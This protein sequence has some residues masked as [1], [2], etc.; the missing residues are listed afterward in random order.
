MQAQSI[1][2]SKHQDK[3]RGIFINSLN[4]FERERE[5]KTVKYRENFT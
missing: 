5:K 3:E 2:Q 4:I 1:K